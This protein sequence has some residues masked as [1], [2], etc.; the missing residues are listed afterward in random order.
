MDMWVDNQL[1][2]FL[3][4]NFALCE[5]EV[6]IALLMKIQPVSGVTKS[7]LVNSV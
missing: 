6:I 4:I 2:R 7:R 3:V 5:I 1:V